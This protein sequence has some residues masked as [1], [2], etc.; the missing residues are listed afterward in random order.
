LPVL[1]RG[2]EEL[3]SMYHVSSR[4]MIIVNAGLLLHISIYQFPR[5]LPLCIK[6]VLPAFL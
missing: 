5:P 6:D 4:F 1:R 3:V 2:V